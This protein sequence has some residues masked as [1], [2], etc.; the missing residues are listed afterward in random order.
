[1]FQIAEDKRGKKEKQKCGARREEIVKKNPIRLGRRE[2]RE[3][4]RGRG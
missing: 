4:K 3:T 1:L 2:Q